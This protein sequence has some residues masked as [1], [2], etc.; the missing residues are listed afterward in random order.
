MVFNKAD[1]LDARRA[2]VLAA[3]HDGVA[4]SAIDRGT[5]APLLHRVDRM[6]TTRRRLTTQAATA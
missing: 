5:L 2:A 6:L 1:A 3:E 4:L